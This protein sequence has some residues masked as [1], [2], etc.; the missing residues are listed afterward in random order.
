MKES[1]KI[2][3]DWK[4]Q[5]ANR[6]KGSIPSTR[7]GFQTGVIFTLDQSEIGWMKCGHLSFSAQH[8]LHLRNAQTEASRIH[9]NRSG[10]STTSLI[11]TNP[12]DEPTPNQT[13]LPPHPTSGP[14]TSAPSS[15]PAT[16]AHTS[17]TAPSHHGTRA[18]TAPPSAP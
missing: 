5:V 17:A 1:R 14:F 4:W 6:K 15:T 18:P 12:A 13:M 10:N 11:T 8:F 2:T 3:P 9:H 16:T 7:D